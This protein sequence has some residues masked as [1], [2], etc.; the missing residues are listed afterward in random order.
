MTVKGTVVV[1]AAV[2]WGGAAAAAGPGLDLSVGEEE[3]LC[4][5]GQKLCPPRVF[6]MARLEKERRGWDGLE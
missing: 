6:T 4:T 5:R 2:V 3:E 1:A